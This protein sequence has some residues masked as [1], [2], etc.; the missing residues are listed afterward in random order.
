[1]S[2]YQSF[3]AL[4]RAFREAGFP[5]SR[6]TIMKWVSTQK[7]VLPRDPVTNRPTIK[8]EEIE[9]IVKAFLPG[10]AGQWACLDQRL[11]L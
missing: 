9:E 3:P 2:K 4:M 11:N 1:M 8:E 7:L 5:R 10:G 6:N